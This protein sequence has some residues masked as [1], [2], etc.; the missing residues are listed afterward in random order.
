LIDASTANKFIELIL[1]IRKS[2]NSSKKAFKFDYYSTAYWY[3]DIEMITLTFQCTEKDFHP[4][5][6]IPYKLMP[7]CTFVQQMTSAE[8]RNST[9]NLSTEITNQ[10][11]RESNLTAQDLALKTI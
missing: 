9:V 3:E 8:F 11:I 1:T 6:M 2:P 4:E 10:D 5:F 7:G